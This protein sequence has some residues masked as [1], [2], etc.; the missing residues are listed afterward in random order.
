M[1][2][3]TLEEWKKT[4]SQINCLTDNS[5]LE[6]TKMLMGSAIGTASKYFLDPIPFYNKLGQI[7]STLVGTGISARTDAIKMNMLN[8]DYT[9][10]SRFQ[11]RPIE[12]VE[13]YPFFNFY[14][15]KEDEFNYDTFYYKE[16]SENGNENGSVIAETLMEVFLPFPEE[17]SNKGVNGKRTIDEKTYNT[18]YRKKEDTDIKVGQDLGRY[19]EWYQND[20]YKERFFKEI[21][22]MDNTNNWGHYWTE[23][24]VKK[25]D[26]SINTYYMPNLFYIIVWASFSKIIRGEAKG[27]QLLM[28]QYKRRV[29]VEDL[30][31]NFWVISQILD[32]VVN[33][34]WGPYGLVEVVK[35]LINK[36]SQIENFLGLNQIEKIELLHSGSND[37]YFDMYSRFTLS[38]LGLRLKTKSG[39]RIIDNI[40][41]PHNEISD[42]NSTTLNYSTKKELF[43]GIQEE[44]DG[45]SYN[46][47]IFD[48]DIITSRDKVNM[49]NSDTYLSL[50]TVIDA[51]NGNIV[52]NEGG[53]VCVAYKNSEYADFLRALDPNS[54]G[55]ISI[56]ELRALENDANFDF[57]HNILDTQS[58][59]NRF[60]NYENAK[61]QLSKKDMSSSKNFFVPAVARIPYKLFEGRND[62][63]LLEFGKKQIKKIYNEVLSL[64]AG[65]NANTQPS[66][67]VEFLETLYEQ[68]FN[69][70]Q[71]FDFI[72]GN[73]HI[74]EKEITSS[75][76]K[77]Y[78]FIF[79]G[80][81]NDSVPSFNQIIYNLNTELYGY[82]LYAAIL[83]AQVS[84][85]L[86]ENFLPRY[87]LILYNAET[88]TV[89]KL[90]FFNYVFDVNSDTEINVYD[91]INTVKNLGTNMISNRINNVIKYIEEEEKANTGSKNYKYYFKRNDKKISLKQWFIELKHFCN[92]E[93]LGDIN[94]SEK[95]VDEYNWSLVKSFF[96]ISK[97]TL[98]DTLTALI[99]IEQPTQKLITFLKDLSESQQK[100]QLSITPE[101]ESKI[102]ETIKT[103]QYELC[104]NILIFLYDKNYYKNTSEILNI[105]GVDENTYI[106]FVPRSDLING[107]IIELRLTGE[108]SLEGRDYTKW[109]YDFKD[110]KFKLSDSNL[111]LS[112]HNCFADTP[113]QFNTKTTLFFKHTT[114]IF[115]SKT[116]MPSNVNEWFQNGIECQYYR[117]KNS[118][119]KSQYLSTELRIKA[120]MLAKKEMYE[121]NSFISENKRTVYDENGKLIRYEFDREQAYCA[122]TRANLTFL[123]TAS[124]NER[125][126]FLHSPLQL[127]LSAGIRGDSESI[128]STRIDYDYSN[129]IASLD[130]MNNEGDTC[131]INDIKNMLY[132]NSY[133]IS[134]P[135]HIEAIFGAR[136]VAN[137]VKKKK[138]RYIVIEKEPGNRHTIY[139]PTC[140]GLS[141]S[142]GYLVKKDGLTSLKEIQHDDERTM[143]QWYTKEGETISYENFYFIPSQAEYGVIDLNNIADIS[144]FANNFMVRF[145]SSDLKSLGTNEEF[146]TSLNN[147][148][149]IRRPIFKM[150][151]FFGEDD[152]N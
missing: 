123:S 73:T 1:A 139:G 9:G 27:L 30:N 84:L 53:K 113:H 97:G 137:Y 18:V 59:L 4:Y 16:N 146:Y 14:G 41:T 50:S 107:E 125:G 35:M 19:T 70:N 144:S 28:P 32:A 92:G 138:I 56:S 105:S 114:P 38:S 67:N 110:K 121:D 44:I 15:Y 17:T 131:D 91:T 12:S 87:N 39:E 65:L 88:E 52:K 68:Y 124:Y 25:D 101:N 119:E 54:N 62:T 115:T 69:I 26:G 111:F 126:Q 60:E 72:S 102:I 64:E 95:E 47:K 21:L 55:F 136:D 29:E 120:S 31:K 74:E 24:E 109:I 37:V 49:D 82:N 140:I 23:I 106:L 128:Q 129:S 116:T 10:G 118:G 2:K 7:Y 96:F 141:M 75:D 151:Y 8:M 45:N 34:L 150:A 22:G 89:E 71:Y 127:L 83:L 6:L 152:I 145:Y 108:N 13:F 43:E 20:E 104:G 98:E 90:D 143:V 57:S 117:P 61:E 86:N 79:K 93:L 122:A 36:I 63:K 11:N 112:L 133:E 33:T 42:R 3:F 66:T 77:T 132:R 134:R 130:V 103:T 135:R 94:V 100:I 5:Y 46:G 58:S 147:N 81:D 78:K 99:D 148:I 48:S 76:G 80:S 142:D 85:P 51:I 149:I 40:F